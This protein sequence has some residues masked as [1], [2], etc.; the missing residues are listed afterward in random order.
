[1]T[2]SVLWLVLMVPWFGLQ[3]VTVIF[4][5]YTH[6]LAMRLLKSIVSLDILQIVCLLHMSTTNT[7]EVQ[8][9]LFAAPVTSL[10]ADKN[11]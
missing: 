6:F 1:M 7:L 8:M 3:C 9:E 11:A 10:D 2:V 5:G 4:P